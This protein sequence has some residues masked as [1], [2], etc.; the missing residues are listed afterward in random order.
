VTAAGLLPGTV[1]HYRLVAQNGIAQT[2]GADQTLKT[3]GAPPP[4]VATGTAT[5][6]GRNSATLTGVVNP[7]NAPTTYEFQYGLTTGYGQTTAT[8]A[9]PAGSVPVT[10]ASPVGG[11][12]AG[13]TFHFRIVAIHGD[14][15]PEYGADQTFMT[16]PFPRPVPTLTVAST[17]RRARGPFS[18]TT[19]GKVAG[20]SSI[21][22]NLDCVGT[23]TVKVFDGRRRIARG[24]SAVGP[25]CTFSVS[26]AIPRLRGRSRSKHAT[27]IRLKVVTVFAGNGY[28]APRKGRAQTITVTRR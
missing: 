5:G 22:A 9:V 16:E 1:Y 19:L 17:P 4:T 15:P 20:P 6:V 27:A 21:P 26:T 10:V 25:G 13:V 7:N 23:I 3:G 2:V 28:L 8:G 14:S 24:T 12:E 18:L 11:L